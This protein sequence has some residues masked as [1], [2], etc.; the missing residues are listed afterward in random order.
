MDNKYQDYEKRVR[1][2]R[3]YYRLACPSKEEKDKF[4]LLVMKLAEENSVRAFEYL[5]NLVEK[6]DSVKEGEN[7]LYRVVDSA[8]GRTY[9][10]YKKETDAWEYIHACERIDLKKG[11][12]T[13][14]WYT[15]KVI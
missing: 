2:D 13:P 1:A 12:Y 9:A 6:D 14:E 11:R 15:V 10:T 8:T 7:E 4:R 5:N 3:V